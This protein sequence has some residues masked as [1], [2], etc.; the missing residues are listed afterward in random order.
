MSLVPKRVTDTVDSAAGKLAA[1]AA[2]TKRA[3]VTAAVVAVAALAVAV[4]SLIVAVI[5]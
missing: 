2:D 5:R 3:V 4:I 1:T